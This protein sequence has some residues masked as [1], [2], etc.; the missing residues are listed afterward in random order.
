MRPQ[1]LILNARI[2]EKAHVGLWPQSAP[3]AK[4]TAN[5]RQQMPMLSR[6]ISKTTK[7]CE[8]SLIVMWD[9][10]L[11]TPEL[12]YPGE[13]GFSRTARQIADV[14]LLM[15]KKMR[16]ECRISLEYHRL[17]VLL[18]P[19]F[20]AIMPIRTDMLPSPSYRKR[21]EKVLNHFVDRFVL[22][23]IVD[24]LRSIGTYRRTEGG[25][26]ELFFNW[27]MWLLLL[28]CPIIDGTCCRPIIG[29]AIGT[30]P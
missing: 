19:S 11:V 14:H 1:C 22:S 20:V 4:C 9:C 16:S 13:P 26:M 24:A 10:F 27:R 2:H 18:C 17:P 30:A 5:P 25:R 23:K 12:I 7:T 21:L 6:Y 15:F 29:V 28:P 8:D 3:S